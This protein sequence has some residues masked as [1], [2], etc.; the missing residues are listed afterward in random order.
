MHYSK[1]RY[2]L[3][4]ENFAQDALWFVFVLFILSVYRAAF[5]VDFYPSLPADTPWTDLLLTMWYGLRISLK[6]AGAVFLPGFVFGTLLQTAWPKWNG[7]KFR[8]IWACV[9]ITGFSLLFQSRIPYYQEFHNAFSPFV[10]NTL[11][12]DVNAIVVTSIKQYGAVW[13][14]LLGLVC[15]A[16]FIWGCKQWFKI[17][18]FI[19]KP[20]LAVRR[21][22]LVVICL[23]LL[24][25]PLAIFV[26]RGGSFTYAG[27]IYWKNAARM[28]E[29]LLNEAILDDV[30]AL[31]KAS[32]IYKKFS[33]SFS[34]LTASE[35][36]SAA[37]R[38]SGQET[39]TANSLLPLLEKTAQGSA[40]KKPRHIFV[41]VAETY[42][43][44]PLLEEYNNLPIAS[45]LRAIAARPDA[46]SV[47]AFMPASNGTMFGLTSV[48]LG[49][50]EANLLTANR[51]TAQKPYESSLAVQLAKNGYKTRF[52]YG[53]YPSWENIG[54]FMNNQGID[55]AFYAADF[56]ANG[57][58]WGVSDRE[59][60][61]G[62]AKQ[63]GEEPSFNLILTSSNHPPYTVDM[64]KEPG[65]TSEA[66]LKKLLPST[67]ADEKLVTD[68]MRHFEYADKYLADFILQMY[69]KYP[70][71]LF[72]ITGDHA[73]RWTLKSSPSYYERYAVPL[74][75]LGK[76]ITQNMLPTRTSGAHMDIVPTVME[77][78]LTKGTPY[79]ALGK[80]VLHGQEIGLHAYTFITPDFV[81][82]ESAQEL[83]P[84]PGRNA[85]D[86]SADMASLLQRV[87]DLRKITAWRV[88]HGT[89]LPE[90]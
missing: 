1:S 13:R 85:N 46:L 73:D 88:L 29:H 6:T 21:K 30:Q 62:V 5:L 38:L 83:Q 16:A 28:G 67:V 71:S 17:T 63:I 86:S 54:L 18:T 48:L 36:R 37:A 22:W 66:A 20:L 58:V 26:R 61:Q 24:L 55:K 64:T 57:G 69:Q 15:A 78:V 52:F 25:V 27:S 9:A 14:I 82:E 81:F 49:L 4:I 65:L 56:N 76:G 3:F 53:G 45:G 90:K 87:Q 50:P 79:Y 75:I 12:D 70:D 41:I 74:I 51:P 43:M 7:K 77:L 60:L 33:K 80:S 68:R 2:T 19:A 89:D 42:M 23:C 34:N 39:Y 84:L 40:I 31:Y 35:V 47:T 10:F 32:R 59:F 8:F 11:H 72:I 44:W